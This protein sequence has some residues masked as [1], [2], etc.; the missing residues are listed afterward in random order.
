MSAV[1]NLVIKDLQDDI[2]ETQAIITV[3][4]LPTIE[5]ERKQKLET[6]RS[7]AEKVH[8]IANAPRFSE[9]F[10]P[11]PFNS[12][13]FMC[14]E[15]TGVPAE[16]LRVHLLDAHGIGVIATSATDVRIAFSCL[17]VEE[18]EPLFEALHQ[19]IQELT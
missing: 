10:R 4:D 18:V 16:K 12:G 7:R 15:V 1:V 8:E 3:S 6:L 19:A 17:E 11:Y 2:D 13:Y 9:S 14:V 5:A